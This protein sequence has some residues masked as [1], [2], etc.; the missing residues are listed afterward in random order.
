[1]NDN[2]GVFISS[3]YSDI[4]LWLYW[5]I[6]QAT[7]YKSLNPYWVTD[8]GT[9]ITLSDNSSHAVFSPLFML[10]FKCATCSLLPYPKWS[11]RHFRGDYGWAVCSGSLG[12]WLRLSLAPVQM[13]VLG[14]STWFLAQTGEGGCPS[15]GFIMDVPHKCMNHKAPLM[16]TLKIDPQTKH[17]RAQLHILLYQLVWLQEQST[18][19]TRKKMS[20]NIRRPANSPHTQHE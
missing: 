6:R 5:K 13:A 2:V 9:E 14:P 12:L 1:M 7:S 8:R 20:V 18:I 15:R 16:C 4:F 11:R 17:T 3:W 19:E 10:I